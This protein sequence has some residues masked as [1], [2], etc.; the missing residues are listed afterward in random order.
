MITGILLPDEGELQVD[1]RITGL[2]ELGTGFNPLLTGR[3]NIA[4]NGL[5]LGMT[6][7]D[8][9]LKEPIIIDFAELG[10]FIDE[11]LSTLLIRY[12]Y[13]ACI[14]HSNKCRSKLFRYR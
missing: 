13:E 8:V 3:Q 14:C 6:N 9:E 5:L 12:E 4:M 7:E 10:I 1:G 11:P 2:L